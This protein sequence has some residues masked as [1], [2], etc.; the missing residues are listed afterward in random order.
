MAM[1]YVCAAA[2][3]GSDGAAVMVMSGWRVSGEQIKKREYRHSLRD[4]N[5]KI[6]A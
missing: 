2:N 3:D 5:G 1:F 6:L 4:S